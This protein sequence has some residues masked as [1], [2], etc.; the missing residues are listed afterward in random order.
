VAAFRATLE[1]VAQSDAIVNVIDASGVE[2]ET[3]LRVVDDTLAA[4]G[5]QDI[6]RIRVLNKVDTLSPLITQ[7]LSRSLDALPV[8]A[9]NRTGFEALIGH[10]QAVLGSVFRGRDP[11][12]FLELPPTG[13]RELPADETDIY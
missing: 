13:E 10:V 12:R 1:E 2:I 11:G 4:L 3:Q 7:S 5:C 8:S 9:L 6:P